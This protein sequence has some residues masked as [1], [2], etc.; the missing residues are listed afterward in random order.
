M[1][2][3]DS[4][5]LAIA[6]LVLVS[7]LDVLLGLRTLVRAVRL[8]DWQSPDRPV[9]SI[10]V[11][12]RNEARGIER[13]MGSLLTQAW[14][15]LEVVAVDDRSEDETGAILDRLAHRDSRLT[16]L[17]VTE[18]PAGWLGKN[19]AL[20]VGA[21]RARGAWILFA[22]ADVVMDP[23]LLGRVLRY[24][25]ERS[26]DHIAVGPELRL[27]GLLLE[28]FSIGFI[29]NFHAFMRPWKARDPRS[30]HF[31]GIGAFNLVRA[32]AYRRA[33]GHAKIRLRPDDDIKLGK[34]LKASGARQDLV[35]GKGMASVEWYHSWSELIHGLEKNAFAVLEYRVGVTVPAVLVHLTLGLGPLI[36]L[37]AL[38]GPARAGSAVAVAWSLFLY[39]VAARETAARRGTA[40]LYPLFVLLFNWI[41]LR[42]MVVNLAN[43][44]IRWRGTFYPLAELRRN[45]V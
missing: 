6:F 37:V 10:V 39:T 22:D 7:G 34:I 26:F 9:V 17:H 5:A 40:L 31:I 44:G 13:A 14:P 19:H 42:T 32:A 4:A 38:D 27:P 18:L 23:G 3:I 43:G 33:G 35:A 30:R 11:A 1:T 16:V 28:A 45:R 25:V 20:H 2:L 41:V 12:A 36:G 21:E 24:A 8:P 29:L 15:A